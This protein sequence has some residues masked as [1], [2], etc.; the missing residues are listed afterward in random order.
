MDVDEYVKVNNFGIKE[1]NPFS[2]REKEKQ[3]IIEKLYERRVS[4]V[5]GPS[6]CGKTRLALEV[7]KEL[8]TNKQFDAF[9][10]RM[11]NINTV[12]ELQQLVKGD[13]KTLFLIDDANRIKFIQDVINF[14]EQQGNENLLF[15]VR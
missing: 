4:I 2:F 10:I 3:T 13:K 7:A 5:Y 9:C 11:C 14:V 12:N 8:K 6:G 1:D 15:Y